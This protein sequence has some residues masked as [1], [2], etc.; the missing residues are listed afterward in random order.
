MLYWTRYVGRLLWFCLSILWKNQVY[1]HWCFYFTLSHISLVCLPIVR[2]SNFL[3]LKP[4]HVEIHF[5]PPRSFD[6]QD[7]YRFWEVQ[8]CTGAPALPIKYWQSTIYSRLI[9][10]TASPPRPNKGTN[11]WGNWNGSKKSGSQTFLFPFWLYGLGK[12]LRP[13]YL[14]ICALL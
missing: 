1:I 13:F 5:D 11:Q 14:H 9:F 12:M 3:A 6:V 4:F 2:S 10:L 8:M 7:V